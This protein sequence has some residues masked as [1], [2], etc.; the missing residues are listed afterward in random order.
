MIEAKVICDSLSLDGDRVTTIQL[1]YPRSIHSQVLTH[2]AF[3]RNSSS[4]RAIPIA[5]L[6]EQVRTDRVYPSSW[7][8]NAKGMQPTGTVSAEN[9]ILARESWNRAAEAAMAEAGIMADLGIAKEISNRVL[10]PFSHIQTIL[11]A[12]EFG[13]FD[14]LRL[15]DAQEEMC[16]LANAMKKAR[17]DS[18]PR[19]LSLGEWHL[20]YIT[21]D[22]EVTIEDPELLASISAARCARVSYLLHDGAKPPLEKDLDLSRMLRGDRHMSPFEHPCRAR[23]GQFANFNGFEITQ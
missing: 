1:R 9:A 19:I 11:T 2:R 15:K 16:L 14:S 5:K 4:S 6:I 13:N 20:P 23:R 3:S 17:D 12:T 18:M 10:E 8:K 22:D 7:R 21:F